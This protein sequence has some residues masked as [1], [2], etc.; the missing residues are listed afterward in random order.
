MMEG[1]DILWLLDKDEKLGGVIR[2][3]L[4]PQTVYLKKEQY[5]YDKTGFD[6]DWNLWM[7]GP[8]E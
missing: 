8:W 6:I 3:N 2:C 7:V 5:Q 4:M 1:S